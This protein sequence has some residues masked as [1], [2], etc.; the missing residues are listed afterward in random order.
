[1]NVRTLL[2]KLCEKSKENVGSCKS[3]AAKQF[4]ITGKGNSVWTKTPTAFE[5]EVYPGRFAEIPVTEVIPFE[6]GEVPAESMG[7]F[8][9]EM[10]PP[11]PKFP[12]FIVKGIT[13]NFF[14]EKDKILLNFQQVMINTKEFY[15]LP[16]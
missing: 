4:I 15:Q 12:T 14:V 5:K 8:S 3:S 7:F 6:K 16:E 1:M 11:S 13:E 2:K 10:E 9:A